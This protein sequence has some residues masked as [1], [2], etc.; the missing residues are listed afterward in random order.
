MRRKNS[1]LLAGL[2]S[3]LTLCFVGCAEYDS[4]RLAMALSGTYTSV[5]HQKF[6]NDADGMGCDALITAT[7]ELGWKGMNINAQMALTFHFDGALSFPTQVLHYDISLTGD[8]SV[9]GDSLTIVPDPASFR[10][11]YVGSDAKSVTE[12]AMVRNLK[13]YVQDNIDTQIQRHLT[14]NSEVRMD[15]IAVMQSGVLGSN[16]MNLYILTK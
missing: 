9:D 6:Q 5:I 11:T 2:I 8:W 7:E 16:D 4:A 10:A 12:E 14:A 15:V 1:L 3:L 13:R